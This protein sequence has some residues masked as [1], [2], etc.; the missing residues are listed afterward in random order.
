MGSQLIDRNNVTSPDGAVHRQM[1]E[2]WQNVNKYFCL[3]VYQNQ[4]YH[5]FVKENNKFISKK[6]IIKARIVRYP[7]NAL[8]ANSKDRQYTVN[9]QEVS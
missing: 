4:R 1:A 5:F 9:S 2:L 7:Y 8:H 3:D 6:P